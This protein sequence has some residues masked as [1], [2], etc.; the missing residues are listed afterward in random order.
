MI[1]TKE[2]LIE[3]VEKN[4][5]KKERGT[6]HR[7]KGKVIYQ[8]PEEAVVWF[9]CCQMAKDIHD[10]Y[11]VVDIADFIKDGYSS[12][13]PEVDIQ[14]W[15]DGMRGEETMNKDE[16]KYIEGIMKEHFGI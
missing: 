5:P 13:D 6:S 12:F 1:N 2:A 10:N 8:T 16:S 3:W 11:S 9:V 4:V 7:V 14:D 15:I